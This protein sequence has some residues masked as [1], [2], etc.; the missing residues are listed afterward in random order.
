MAH[1]IAQ[2]DWSHLQT[3]GSTFT[4]TLSQPATAGS[5]LV[6]SSAGGA[7]ATASGFTSRT[8]YGSGTQD[9]S[10]QDFVCTGGETSISVTLNGSGDN[11]S[12]SVFEFGP[13]LTFKGFSNN[14]SGG[15]V[16][17]T[18]DFQICPT[19]AVSV[20]AQSIVLAIWSVGTG[21]AYSAA[22]RW[23]QMGPFGK[24][25]GTGAN[26]PGNHTEFIWATGIADIDA[27]HSWPQQ[28][29]AGSY[30]ATSV[31]LSA[32]TCYVAQVVY[33]DTSGV[34]TVPSAP[35][36]IVRENSLPGTDYGNWFLGING[37]NSTIAGY[38]DKCSYAPGD[39]VNFKV[40]STSH[41]FRVEVY[42]LGF[43]GREN[44]GARN[45]LGCQG[46]YL[47][48][49]STTQ[50]SPSV[51]ATTGST[52]CSWTTNATWSV[53]S[54]AVPGI[55]YVLFRRTDDTTKVSTGH[56]VVRGTSLTGKVV[57]VIPDATH[58]AYNIWGATTDS[59]QRGTGTWT[60]RNLYQVG[61]DGGA[62]NFAHRGYAVSFDRPYST[63]SSQDMT[64][65]FD[66]EH[67]WI[68]FAE[69][70]GYNITYISDI[71]LMGNT[72]AMNGASLVVMLGHHE[73]WATDMYN[74]FQNAVNA[75]VN[76]TII[77][78]N[79]AL[80]HIRFASGDTSFRTV[81]C[82]KDSGSVDDSPGFTGT[83][84]DPV[85]Y[86]GTWRDSRT[87]TPNNPDIRRENVLTGQLF[88]A[89]GP[90]GTTAVVGFAYKSVPIWRNSPGIQALTTGQSYTTP[91]NVVGYEVDSPDGSAGQP[92][93][94]VILW[95]S[96]SYTFT[97]VTN[98]AGSTYGNS[99]SPV[100]AWTLY[101]ASS[102][103]LVWNVG[104]WRGLISISRWNDDSAPTGN[105]DIN[106]Q[107]AFLAMMYDLGQVPTTLR[108]LKQ[109]EDTDVTNP[110]TGA[111]TGNR[112]QVAQA[113]GLTGPILKLTSQLRTAT[114]RS[115]VY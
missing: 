13:G 39:T 22:N 35:N 95:G 61:G 41:A 92:T 101:Q 50:S 76:T 47:A 20:T 69:A 111:P 72:T 66:C 23:R 46:G 37:T 83:G 113:Y 105:I 33:T 102:G 103:A 56:F 52:S 81:I 114:S 58:Q 44:F 1:L 90:I 67:N 104:N 34:Q 94:L 74:A 89:S 19:S 30:E 73:Y 93:N 24:L 42:R 86:T 97:T 55:Y 38:T 16:Q 27:T 53:P 32:G 62:A 80:W 78:S 98:A 75:G 12:G 4:V 110:A 109:G 18:S 108:S 6:M 54:D 77:S 60:G 115:S 65:I 31:Y 7:I 64:Y 91:V 51:D 5:T 49:T 17:Q 106:W 79:T 82:Y 45:V 63:Q 43:Y 14:G 48:G 87:S 29:S 71:D 96:S 21:T 88:V 70:Q 40:D 36:P 99:G 68:V 25:Y 2:T 112:T 3:A 59:G 9:V 10:W 15:T 100:V 84:I 8:T 57:A 28:L 11:V 85:S 26:Q 107:N